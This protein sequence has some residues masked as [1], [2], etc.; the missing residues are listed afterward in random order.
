MLQ[1]CCSSSSSFLLFFCARARVCFKSSGFPTFGLSFYDFRFSVVFTT[2][3]TINARVALDD[4]SRSVRYI[5]L[6]RECNSSTQNRKARAELTFCTSK[7]P[8]LRKLRL[9][10]YICVFYR[11]SI[12]RGRTAIG[13]TTDNC[14]TVPNT[15]ERL[16]TAIEIAKRRD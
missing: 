3:L 9:R 1:L 15:Y 10:L 4:V 8:L 2:G 12:A 5:N 14:T 11:R 13:K 6:K 7:S 16:A